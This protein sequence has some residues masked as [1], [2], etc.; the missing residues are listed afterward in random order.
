MMTLERK[1][2][3]NVRW[4]FSQMDDREKLTNVYVRPCCSILFLHA[5]L[6][7]H[8]LKQIGSRLI[9]CIQ[10]ADLVLESNQLVISPRW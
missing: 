1:R 6:Y 5:F 8:K 3:L 10:P 7:I 4:I 9:S 2:A